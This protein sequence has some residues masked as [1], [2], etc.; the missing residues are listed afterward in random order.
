MEGLK[1]LAIFGQL[2]HSRI[3]NSQTEIIASELAK[4]G[5]IYR[6]NVYFNMFINIP[7]IRDILPIW[8]FI[9]LEEDF[10]DIKDCNVIVVSGRKMIR[11]AKHIRKH[12]FPTTKIVQ[13]GNPYCSFSKN[14]ILLRQ[15]TSRSVIAC[16]NTIKINGLLCNKIDKEK[17][18]EECKK[19]SKIIQMLKGEYISVFIGKNTYGY[20]F[21]KYDVII[22]QVLKCI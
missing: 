12:M 1:V 13:I 18:E 9:K 20:K 3:D 10:R 7:I 22:L 2:K 16:K 4:N 21:C 11:F 15:E 8:L 5:V 14:D 17:A 6:K 19:F